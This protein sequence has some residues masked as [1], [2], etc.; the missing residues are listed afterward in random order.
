[1]NKIMLTLKWLFYVF[2][3][4]WV[5]EETGP[6][7]SLVICFMILESNSHYLHIRG[8]MSAMAEGLSLEQYRLKRHN[9][10]FPQYTVTR[11]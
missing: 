9:D 11:E 6:V 2:C 5:F 1:M 4:Y 3:M 8:I 7:T 10:Q